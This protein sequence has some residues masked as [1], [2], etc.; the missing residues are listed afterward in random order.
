[1]S[2][3]TRRCPASGSAKT[4][5]R[6]RATSGARA[7]AWGIAC[8]A[9]T[10]LA[11]SAKMAAR[12]R[13]HRASVDPC[14]RRNGARGV[15]EYSTRGIG[16]APGRWARFEMR[17]LCFE[18]N[19]SEFDRHVP[20]SPA[21]S[22]RDLESAQWAGWAGRATPRV[23]QRHT[24]TRVSSRDVGRVSMSVGE[25]L[26]GTIVSVRLVRSAHRHHLLTRTERHQITRRTSD[27]SLH[28]SGPHPEDAREVHTLQAE[29]DV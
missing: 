18:P 6:T 19:S 25:R 9:R 17:V 7:A 8:A 20:N 3:A 13:L 27:A 26:K 2:P 23:C 22:E 14:R 4:R 16:V 29:K 15:S 10:Q 24:A 1:M 21:G 5:R 11:L 12:C 28:G